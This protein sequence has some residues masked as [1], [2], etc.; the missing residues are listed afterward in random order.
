MKTL[1]AA[2]KEGLVAGMRSMP[3]NAYDR[4]TVDSQIEQIGILTGVMPKMALVD[5]CYRGVQASA[6]TPSLV[7]HMRRLPKRLKK[8][9]KQ[10]QVV[11]PIIGQAAGPQL[12]EGRPG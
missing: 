6:D 8:L 12:V 7:S 1:V 11:E 4:H 3:G 9:L 10:R 2:T 5:R